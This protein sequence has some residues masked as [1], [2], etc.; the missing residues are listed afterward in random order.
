[1]PKFNVLLLLN[2]YTH[3]I[4]NRLN[5]KYIRYAVMA[6]WLTHLTNVRGHPA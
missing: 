6:E 3:A 2:L 1:M 5:L 4:T